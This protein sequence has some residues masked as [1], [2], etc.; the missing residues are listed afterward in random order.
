V[1]DAADVVSLVEGV[2]RA[3]QEAHQWAVD[4]PDQVL[5]AKQD[6]DDR[7]TVVVDEAA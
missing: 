4:P 3:I 1:H 5:D 6:A 2:W 7:V